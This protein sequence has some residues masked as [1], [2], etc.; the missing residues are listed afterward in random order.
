[1]NPRSIIQFGED[2]FET[3]TGTH[4]TSASRGFFIKEKGFIPACGRAGTGVYIW[5]DGYFAA[6]LARG[7]YAFSSHHG[8]YRGDDDPSGVILFC[9]AT[10]PEGNTLDLEDGTLRELIIDVAKKRGSLFRDDDEEICR[11]YDILIQSLE[12]QLGI[13]FDAVGVRVAAHP[14]R[15]VFYPTK[16]LGAPYCY[17]IRS[18][19]HL[20]VDRLGEI[21]DEQS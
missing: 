16:L 7:W 13:I 4:G 20:K 8:A 10:F 9:R 2:V 18:H 19:Q 6:D 17:L 5:A 1:M 21:E 11:C 12:R 14:S 3:I 15:F